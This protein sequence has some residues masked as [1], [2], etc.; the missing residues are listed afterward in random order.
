MILLDT[1]HFSVLT[2]SRQA[3]HAP[4]AARLKSCGDSL[5][6]PVISVEEQMR[7]WLAEIGAPRTFTSNYSPMTG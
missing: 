4:L 1:D 3:G 2:D 6:L 5:A 7:G